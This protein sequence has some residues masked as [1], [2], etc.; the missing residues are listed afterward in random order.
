[1]KNSFKTNH[2]HRAGVIGLLTGVLLT[3][4]LPLRTAHALGISAN[5]EVVAIAADKTQGSTIIEWDAGN[6]RGAEVWLE[7]EGDDEIRFS[8]EPKGSKAAIIT[9][10]KKHIFRLYKDITG[11]SVLG[12]IVVTGSRASQPPPPSTPPTS[13]PSSG[14][15]GGSKAPAT[16]GKRKKPNIGNQTFKP[17]K[18]GA[19]ESGLSTLNIR[20]VRVVPSAY[21][22]RISFDTFPQPGLV[23]V[24]EIARVAPTNTAGH[25]S[26]RG[27]DAQARGW[28]IHNRLGDPQ[29]GHYVFDLL[30]A[31]DRVGEPRNIQLTPGRLYHYILTLPGTAGNPTYQETGSFTTPLTSVR[32][33]FQNVNVINDSDDNGNGE[34]R[35]N[36]FLNYGQV[37][38]N[39]D[40]TKGP[41]GSSWL[42][43]GEGNHGLI[44]V[45]ETTGE[46]P[47]LS[48]QVDGEDDDGIVHSSIPTATPRRGPGQSEGSEWN[49]ANASFDLRD[50][51][52]TYVSV[53]FKIHSMPIGDNTGDL[54]FEVSGVIEITRAKTQFEGQT[55]ATANNN[56]TTPTLGKRKRTKR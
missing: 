10:G 37:N 52:G 47:F 4:V 43:W 45:L 56:S 18:A 30:E 17:G 15:A 55:S 34:L 29:K 36:F 11:T 7:V 51:P 8:S 2:K 21:N 12:T 24:I 16:L 42:D 44:E 50:Y 6:N 41:D 20:N 14:G 5:P 49:T 54:E 25:Y 35:F 48:I 3:G 31:N 33:R 19:T 53:P 46:P 28:Q 1:M 26:F 38:E 23:P 22:V 40:Y 9:L 32:V 39:M 27:P 13:I